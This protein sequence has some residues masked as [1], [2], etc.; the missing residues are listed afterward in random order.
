M[1]SMASCVA[2]AMDRVFASVRVAGWQEWSIM[3]KGITPNRPG[4][5]WASKQMGFL[6]T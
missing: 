6:P 3:E 5:E 4:H 1:P 2:Q